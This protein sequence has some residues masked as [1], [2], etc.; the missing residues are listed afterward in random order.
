MHFYFQFQQYKR[1]KRPV[2]GMVLKLRIY[3]VKK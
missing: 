2:L 3:V 1:K